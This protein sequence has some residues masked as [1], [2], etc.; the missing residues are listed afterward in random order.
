MPKGKKGSKPPLIIGE[1]NDPK[2]MRPM[3]ARFLEWM[4]VRNHTERT[5]EGYEKTLRHFAEWTED[6]GIRQPTEVTKSIIEAYQKHLFYRR[7]VNGKPLAYATQC[8]ALASIRS[9]FRYLTRHGF[10]EANPS[11]DIDLPRREQ[12]LPPTILTPSQAETVINQPNVKT[13]LG[14]RDRAMLELLWT[15]A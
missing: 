14:V 9:F 6:R 11:Q 1:K 7:K 5:V 3:M 8:N 4:R 12:R 15:R 13:A 2:D 10:L